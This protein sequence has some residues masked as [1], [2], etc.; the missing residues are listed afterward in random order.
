MN[1][2]MLA[3]LSLLAVGLLARPAQAQES[4]RFNAKS[5]Q[6]KYDVPVYAPR[7]RVEN[8]E[9][10]E[11]TDDFTHAQSG[12]YMVKVDTKKIVDFYTKA[13]GEPKHETTDV[14]NEKWI[15]KKDDEKDNTLKHRVIVQHNKGGKLVHVTLWQ[16]KYQSAADAMDE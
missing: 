10:I 16:R 12:V 11:S 6:A 14:G 8:N 3:L 9:V 15:F 13:L 7:N 4:H 2:T 5:L 1:R